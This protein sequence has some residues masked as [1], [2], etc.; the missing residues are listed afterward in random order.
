MA[1]VSAFVTML[2]FSV[3]FAGTAVA[4]TGTPPP[5]PSL[6]PQ[7]NQSLTDDARQR[8]IIGVIVVVLFAIVWY[9]RRV[10]KKR[11]KSS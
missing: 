2:V 4:Q 11:Q 5:G 3:L 8:V 7:Q 1:R 6:N 9:G 10:R